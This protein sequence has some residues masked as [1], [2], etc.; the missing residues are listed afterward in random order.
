MFFAIASILSWEKTGGRLG[1]GG[2]GTVLRRHGKWWGLQEDGEDAW[3]SGA[4]DEIGCH[5]SPGWDQQAA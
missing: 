2:C 3:E 4:V 5:S 1:G